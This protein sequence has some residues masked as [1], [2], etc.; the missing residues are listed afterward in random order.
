[1]SHFEG[2]CA[3]GAFE[4]AGADFAESWAAMAIGIKLVH[5]KVNAR[6]VKFETRE[7]MRFSSAIK[8]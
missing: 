5:A 8:N 7:Y 6:R 3:E 4:E 1:M 2:A